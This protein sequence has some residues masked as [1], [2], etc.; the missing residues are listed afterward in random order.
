M[1][2]LRVY[3]QY[4]KG[5]FTFGTFSILND[6][7][8]RRLVTATWVAGKLNKPVITNQICYHVTVKKSISP[9]GFICISVYAHVLNIVFFIFRFSA[10]PKYSGSK[11]PGVP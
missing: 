6:R 11:F 7:P 2:W 4:I 8:I 9:P 5:T 3:V 1:V 10:H